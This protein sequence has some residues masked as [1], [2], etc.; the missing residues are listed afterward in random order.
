MSAKG[1]G[2]RA[3]VEGPIVCV[4]DPVEW[5]ANADAGIGELCSREGTVSLLQLRPSPADD[6]GPALVWLTACVKHQ[7]AVRK[8]MRETWDQDEV[9][10]FGTRFLMDNQEAYAHVWADLE[11]DVWRMEVQ[12][13]A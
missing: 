4:G 10:T 5:M 2:S 13:S 11:P 12:A 9:D 8:W 3:L 6:G 1:N 7:R